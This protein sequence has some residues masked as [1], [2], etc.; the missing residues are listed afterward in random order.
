[1][2]TQKIDLTT[3]TS[4]DAERKASALRT[5]L[6]MMDVPEARKEITRANVAWL[7]RNLAIQNSDH[8]MF[9]CAADLVKWLAKW[10]R[11]QC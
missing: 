9:A 6:D 8:P 11:K 1:M 2:R 3:I 5:F 7:S 4:E 10:H